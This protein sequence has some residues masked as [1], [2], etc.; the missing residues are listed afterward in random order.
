MATPGA[1]DQRLSGASPLL[2]EMLSSTIRGQC[3]P[4][5]VRSLSSQHGRSAF[6]LM[7]LFQVGS[8]AQS[9][10]VSKEGTKE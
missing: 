3:L 4:M 8:K 2:C 10:M 5:A 1:R 7:G 6:T 9:F